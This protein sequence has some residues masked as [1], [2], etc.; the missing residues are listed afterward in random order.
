[1][2]SDDWCSWH[3][4]IRLSEAPQF[5][6]KLAEIK[7]MVGERGRESI[8]SPTRCLS[9]SLPKPKRPNVGL[10]APARLCL[11]SSLRLASCLHDTLQKRHAASFVAVFHFL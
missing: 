9:S 10:V 5:S 6:I 1:M 2:T 3:D 8:L 4:L 11:G 7:K